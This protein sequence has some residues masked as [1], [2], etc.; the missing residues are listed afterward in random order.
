[1]NLVLGWLDE[2]V[3][4]LAVILLLECLDEWAVGL[5]L[6]LVVRLVLLEYLCELVLDLTV[7]LMVVGLNTLGWKSAIDMA[8]GGSRKTL[9]I[10]LR[11]LG[12]EEMKILR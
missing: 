5:V 3:V 10:S 6:W 9:D 8:D 1:M 4:D 2:L 7:S 12:I 11:E